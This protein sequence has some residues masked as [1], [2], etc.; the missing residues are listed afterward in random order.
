M[1]YYNI[2]LSEQTVLMGDLKCK[3]LGM[4]LFLWTAKLNM[5]ACGL[6]LVSVNQNVGN[7]LKL[8]YLEGSYESQGETW[9]NEAVSCSKRRHISVRSHAS[10]ICRCTAATHLKKSWDQND[11]ALAGLWGTP[12]LTLWSIDSWEELAFKDEVIFVSLPGFTV[13]MLS[14]YKIQT[15]KQT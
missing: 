15:N 1:T 10:G 9:R 2:I 13:L 3:S 12:K 7:C 4:V 8:L 11:W 14:A 5:A 6:H